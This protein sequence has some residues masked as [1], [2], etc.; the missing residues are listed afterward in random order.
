VVGGLVFSTVFTLVMIPVLHLGLIRLAE[1]IGW[2]TIPP[3]VELELELQ[4]GT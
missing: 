1:R 2:N 3:A 4:E